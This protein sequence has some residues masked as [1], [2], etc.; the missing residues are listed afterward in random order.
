MPCGGRSQRLTTG[1][2]LPALSPAACNQDATR[3]SSNSTS[4]SNLHTGGALGI[5]E[6]REQEKA[7]HSL[8]DNSVGKLRSKTHISDHS[9]L[10]QDRCSQTKCLPCWLPGGEC[11]AR[12]VGRCT[13]SPQACG[14]ARP[15][16]I[17]ACTAH[18]CGPPGAWTGPVPTDERAY[19]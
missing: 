9:G 17:S 6:Q 3:L 10:R 12:T 1:G 8:G 16:H 7:S 5:Q 15:P 13:D 11:R 14:A 19:S 18:D 2:W 4:G